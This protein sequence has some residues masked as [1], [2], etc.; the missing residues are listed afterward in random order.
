M[1]YSYYSVHDRT[2]RST[3][4]GYSTKAINEIFVQ[5][6]ERQIHQSMNPRGVVYRECKDSSSHPNTIPI[7]LFLDVTGS[8]GHIPHE[9]IKTGLPTL[10]GTLIQNGVEDASLMFGAIGDHEVDRFPLQIW[11][12]ESGDVELDMW[13]TRTYLEGGGGGNAGE[14]Y[15]LAWYFAAYHIWTDAFQN[16]NKKGF[17]FTIGDEPCL[18]NLPISA[19]KE[20]MG[21]TTLGIGNHSREDLLLAAQKKNHVFHIHVNHGGRFCDPDWKELLGEYLIQIDDHTQVAKTIA[22]RVIRASNNLIVDKSAPVN[23]IL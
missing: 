6:E 7:Q 20:I 22:D 12:F 4:A 2:I 19:L 17:L 13:L 16:R 21:N 15:L 11:Q 18:K 23:I 1:G 3:A 9:L 10:M 5:N 8:M 14:S